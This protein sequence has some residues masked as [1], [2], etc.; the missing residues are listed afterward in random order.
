MTLP[1]R[2]SLSLKFKREIMTEYTVQ[3][4]SKIAGIS[5]RT[6][7][8]YDRIG[9][10]LPAK[11]T[12]KGY[13]IYQKPELLKL[14]QILFYKELGIPLREIKD[15]LNA[16][17]FDLIKALE[18]HQ[19][20]LIKKSEQ[21]IMLLNTIEKTINSLKNKNKMMKDEELY[22]GFSKEEIN[23][24]RSEVKK[25]WGAKELIEVENKIQKLGKEGWN[26][27]KA[28]GEQINQVLAELMDMH[29]SEKQVQQAVE[30]HFK[31]LNF[32]YEVSK[33][34]YENLG[35][36]Y[37][38]DERFKSYYDK[39]GDDLAVFLRDAIFIFCQNELKVL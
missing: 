17:D 31:H 15:I 7:H 20:E 27:H 34:R 38:E 12:E 18:F 19:V 4:L 11:R 29:P 32:Y 22:E 9:L 21:T 39:Y 3:Q 5:I 13:R 28:K 1:L 24:M 14:Q 10:L 6:L 37:V 23:A 25:K 16:K 30:L 36:M 2:H 35:K 8:H 33:E 26:D